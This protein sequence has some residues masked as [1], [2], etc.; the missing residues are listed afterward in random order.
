MADVRDGGIPPKDP[1]YGNGSPLISA[2][3]LLIL[4]IAAMIG[5]LIGLSVGI[6]AALALGPS[7]QWPW[8]VVVGALATLG[9]G[10]L[11]G[12]GVSATL[13]GLIDHN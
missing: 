11:A 4:I 12:L 1:Y 6:S 9:G 8:R 5:L 13:N 10:T 2:R 7:I 3:S